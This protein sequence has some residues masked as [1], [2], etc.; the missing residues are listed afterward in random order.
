[1]TDIAKQLYRFGHEKWHYLDFKQLVRQAE[2]CVLRSVSYEDY[3][4]LQLVKYFNQITRLK[5]HREKIGEVEDE[6][7]LEFYYRSVY[8]MRDLE[9]LPVLRK[10]ISKAIE[11]YEHVNEHKDLKITEVEENEIVALS[12]VQDKDLFRQLLQAIYTDVEDS[13]FKPDKDFSHKLRCMTQILINGSMNMRKDS[14]EE[15]TFIIPEDI[16]MCCN[17]VR[18]RLDKLNATILDQQWGANQVHKTL[19][20]LNQILMVM[21]KFMLKGFST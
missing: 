14:N 19:D 18:M 13:K 20:A 7:E 9:D 17:L 16:N 3:N 5:A 11:E 21:Q 6:E 1:M 8:Y 2:L 10:F 12:R 15:V 4:A